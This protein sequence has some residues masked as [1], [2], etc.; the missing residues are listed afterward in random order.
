MNTL[1]FIAKG[2]T[3]VNYLVEDREY[4]GDNFDI[5]I[6]TDEPDR[7]KKFY[8][9]ADIR[10]YDEHVFR[11]FDKYTLTYKL[12][13]EKKKPVMY[14]DTGRIRSIFSTD[15]P[16]FDEKNIYKIYTNSNWGSVKSAASLRNIISPYF[17]DGYWNNI[18][19]Y[20]EQQGLDLNKVNP[21]LERVF[22]F[23]VNYEM[24]LV[25]NMLESVRHLFEENSKV[26]KHV[27]KGIGNGEGL[28]LGY[29]LAMCKISNMTIG[30]LPTIKQK[31]F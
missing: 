30:K 14:I 1:H 4:I 31:A 13:Q 22:V 17:E 3:Y 28:A 6:H 25:I 29:A 8:K 11:Y 23:P 16:Y 9:N 5:V 15:L 21:L 26:K 20:F 27:Y 10:K 2:T 19:D 24:P 7:V 18:L 12:T